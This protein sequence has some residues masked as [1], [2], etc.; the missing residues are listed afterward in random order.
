MQT[1]VNIRRNRRFNAC[2]ATCPERVSAND[3]TAARP[4]QDCNMSYVRPLR[5]EYF[6]AK[7]RVWPPL[8][9]VTASAI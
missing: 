8:T 1:L 9:R 4:G 6:T 3:V 5:G 7:T 2:N